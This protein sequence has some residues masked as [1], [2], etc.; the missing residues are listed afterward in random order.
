MSAAAVVRR[1]ADAL[2]LEYE[3]ALFGGAPPARQPAVAPRRD[4]WA[5]LR[6][7]WWAQRLAGK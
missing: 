3:R 7:V 1:E 5:A 6:R 4:L 2:A